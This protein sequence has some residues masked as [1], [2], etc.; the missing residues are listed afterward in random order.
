MF[1]SGGIY[2]E[3]ETPKN[4]KTHSQLPEYEAENVQTFF[5]IEIGNEGEEKEKGRVVFEVFSK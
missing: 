1:T 5:D 2:D 3:K 4:T